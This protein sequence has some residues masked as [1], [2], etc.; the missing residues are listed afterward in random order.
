MGSISINKAVA[1]LKQHWNYSS[2]RPKQAEVITA[3]SNE[4]KV[5][6]LLPT[7]GG[8]SLCYQ[9]P[10]LQLDGITLVI[11]P[12]I[13][14]MEDQVSSLRKRGIVAKA[15][16]SGLR[17]NDID[18]LLSNVN[19]DQTK[20]LYV[21]PERL[22]SDS[23]L[24]RLSQ[25]QIS[26]LAI[27]EAHCI[28]QWGHDFRPAYQLIKEFID[29]NKPNRIIALTGT[30]NENTIAEICA[31]LTIPQT[32][33][34]QDSF[35]RDNIKLAVVRSRDK[36]N[37][38]LKQAKTSAKTIIY[39]R[40]RRNVEMIASFLKSHGIRAAHYH[41]GLSFSD[42]TAIQDQFLKGEIQVV[43]STN[44]F[45]MGIDI[46]D[47]AQIVHYDI[48]PSLE[49]YY[50]EIGRAGRNGAMSS[51]ILLYDDSDL[52]YHQSRVTS[53]FPSFDSLYSTYS[54]VHRYFDNLINEGEGKRRPL[55][56]ISLAKSVGIGSRVLLN[57]L[58]A[59]SKLNCHSIDDN[60]RD[61]HSIK[62]AVSP[63]LLREANL[64]ES[65]KGVLDF[66][67]RHY[68]NHADEWN[69]INIDSMAKGLKKN[70]ELIL[71]SF[72]QL[73]A[74]RL[75]NYHRLDQG[76]VITFNEG[77]LNRKDFRYK[78]NRYTKLK[79]IKEDR[80]NAMKGYI[81]CEACLNEYLLKYFNEDHPD[82]CS[83]CNHC[84]SANLMTI[85]KRDIERMTQAELEQTLVQAME[86]KNHALLKQLQSC[87]QKELSV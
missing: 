31:Q 6:A 27:D 7:G 79:Q 72:S 34:V 23:F 51:A 21:S 69:K 56:L 66:L 76:L 30:A 73:K 63:R 59:L 86:E 47:I 20:L 71:K 35:L 40:S 41:A 43:A 2:L 24:K 22:R 55:N 64:D 85:S 16:H 77:R 29:I 38:I 10:A 81:N 45:G 83:L 48:P 46:P 39:T 67:M 87:H 32:A 62:Y 9:L 12:L 84:L 75:I 17:N 8:K 44:A 57:Q 11:S 70:P 50:Q 68:A 36:M 3:L 19:Y 37:D 61:I 1:D 49:E 60:P 74:K 52:R 82:K 26:M 25:Y 42:K 78:A 53:E 80:M 65:L 18:R 5:L 13:A 33:I 4:N 14:L 54:K 28:S 15:I 58:Q